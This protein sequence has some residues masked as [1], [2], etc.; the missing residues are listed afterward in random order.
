MLIH[1][2]AAAQTFAATLFPWRIARHVR[3][4]QRV[5]GA[6]DRRSI[7]MLSTCTADRDCNG[8]VGRKAGG[9]QS[10]ESASEQSAAAHASSSTRAVR[11]RTASITSASS[12]RNEMLFGDS[13]ARIA[14]TILIEIRSE[15]EPTADPAWQLV[16][17]SA[18][19]QGM[20]VRFASS[21][22]A[23][24][25]TYRPSVRSIARSSVSTAVPA[26]S[27]ELRN[28]SPGAGSTLRRTRVAARRPFSRTFAAEPGSLAS[29]ARRRKWQ[30]Y[31]VS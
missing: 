7:P 30:S 31:D 2:S 1:A 28:E 13:A 24:C 18:L 23:A 4:P 26:L 20:S 25:Q 14:P 19:P 21:S 8:A 6:D 10:G 3:R 12:A 9:P 5:A 11:Q 15:L 27:Q 29:T 16:R 17:G 22:C